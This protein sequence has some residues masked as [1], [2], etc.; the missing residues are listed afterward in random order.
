MRVTATLAALSLLSF[1]SGAYHARQIPG[2]PACA[3]NCL[4]NPTNLGGCAQTD[5]TCLC[6]SLPFVETTYACVLAA[7]QGADQQSAIGVA[8]NLCLV[9]GVTLA[10]E[11]S[12]I[13]AGLS[14]IG[15]GA[16]ITGNG[17]PSGTSSTT[18]APT[19]STGSAGHLTG[20]YLLAT[21]VVVC[22]FAA[23]SP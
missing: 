7:C 9:F 14:T 18:P 2:L 6:K 3:N 1:V 15:S 16:S 11:S 20:G 12:I 10:A 22:V 13:M 5:E 17:S 8:E 19:G 4:N 21:T 23:L